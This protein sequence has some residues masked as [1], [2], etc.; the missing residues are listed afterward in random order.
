MALRLKE[1]HQ[2]LGSD[3]EKYQNN[4][5]K[6]D[7]I[8]GEIDSEKER[9]KVNRNMVDSDRYSHSARVQKYNSSVDNYKNQLKE[10]ALESV[11]RY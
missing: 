5:S 2:N 3:L 9:I 11:S 7:D 10:H 6:L 4:R 1:R 8:S